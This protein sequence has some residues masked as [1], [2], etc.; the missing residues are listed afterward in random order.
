MALYERLVGESGEK[1]SVHAFYG[2]ISEWTW[3]SSSQ[4]FWRDLMVSVFNL[5]AGEATEL[6]TLLT[7]AP[8]RH[9]A[10]GVLMIAEAGG[11][12]Y[13]SAT[14]LE[15][16]LLDD[17]PALTVVTPTEGQVVTDSTPTFSGAAGNEDGDGQEITV[18]IYSEPGTILVQTRTTTRSGATWTVDASPA[19]VNSSY[20]A[21]IRQSTDWGT[22]TSVARA[23]SVLA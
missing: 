12:P 11:S 7:A 8:D 4:E 1:I 14:R 21:E 18:L 20:T 2:F 19:L 6:D 16:R 3:F 15:R 5:D 23:F 22:Q 13:Q 9:S 17:T 10:H